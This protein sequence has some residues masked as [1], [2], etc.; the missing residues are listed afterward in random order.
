MERSSQKRKVY[1]KEK[2]KIKKITLL[3][4]LKTKINVKRIIL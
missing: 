3:F 4:V 1:G 2:K